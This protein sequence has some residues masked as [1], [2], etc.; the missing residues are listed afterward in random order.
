[1][2]TN[3]QTWGTYGT[4]SAAGNAAHGNY[5][6]ALKDIGTLGY[7]NAVGI[8]GMVLGGVMGGGDGE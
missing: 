6:G 4:Y 3:P 5:G 1:M 8:P 2:A 7:Y